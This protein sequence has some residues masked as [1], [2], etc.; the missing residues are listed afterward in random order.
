MKPY[1]HQSSNG[2]RVD[3]QPGKVVCVGRNYADH[4]KE[5]NNPLPS[6]PL[7]FMKPATA[8]TDL[9]Q[10][11]AL[12]VGRGPCHY[13]TE[14]ALLIGQPLTH[15]DEADCL[16][17]ITG[18][19][20]ALDLT[21]RELQDQLKADRHP[22][23]IAKGFDGACPVSAFVP[24]TVNEAGKHTLLNQDIRLHI[25]GELRQ[26]GN[27]GQMITPIARLLAYCSSHFSLMPGDI[28]L[29]GT[30]A[31]VGVLNRGDQLQLA[32]PGL[33]EVTTHV[34]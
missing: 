25:N 2:A 30:P 15:A 18:I 20:I 6:T 23:E 14:L 29:T 28:V 13:E 27:T 33:L 7:L 10:P 1:Q 12:P 34:A 32:L 9:S 31:G 21:L 11:L 22:W 5:L 8:L 3:L 17:A 24:F 16:R 4:A 26:N 19:G